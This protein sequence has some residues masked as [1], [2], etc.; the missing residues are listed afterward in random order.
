MA[1]TQTTPVE[2]TG[3]DLAVST[4]DA[5]TGASTPP[6]TTTPKLTTDLSE[7]FGPQGRILDLT[8]EEIAAAPDGLLVDPTPEQLALRR[9]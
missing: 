2:T 7:A 9:A 1:K 3:E 4:M 6:V 8:D 5:S